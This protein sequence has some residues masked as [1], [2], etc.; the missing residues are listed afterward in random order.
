MGN[1]PKRHHFLP[2]CYLE[3]FAR[4][5]YVWLFDRERNEF[6]RQQPL[7]TSVIKNFYVFENKLGEK[8]YGLETFFSGIEGKA[9]ATIL[10]LETRADISPDRR[11]NLA[12][13]IAL[14]MVRS[15]KFD[16]QTNEIIDAATKHFIKHAV[17]TVEA[18]GELVQRHGESCRRSS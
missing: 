3:G 5:G 6:R 12:V 9:K 8:D 11:L 14:L 18:A 17:P 16:R 10:E 15:P 7:N 4:D 2:K 1:V 13:F